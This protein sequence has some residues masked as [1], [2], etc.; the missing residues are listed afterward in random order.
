MTVRALDTE[1][2]H[3]RAL[4]IEDAEHLYPLYAEPDFVRFISLR[5]ATVAELTDAVAKRL[6]EPKPPGMGNWVWLDRAT[7]AYVGQGGLWPSIHLPGAPVE[8]G[9]FLARDRWG[10]GLAAEAV[11][12][13]LDYAFGE[14]D[15]PEVWATVHVDNERSLALAARFGFAERGGGELPA[16]PHT[17]LALER[18]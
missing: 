5:P 10:Q 15:V 13:Q 6:A 12:A 8:M 9:W 18:P 3:L 4:R 17:F 16:G 7:G 14:L 11:R 2:L 1:R